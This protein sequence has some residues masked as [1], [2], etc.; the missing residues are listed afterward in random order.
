MESEVFS[1]DTTAT[2]KERA[3]FSLV[4]PVFEAAIEVYRKAGF[5]IIPIALPAFPAA[6]LYAIHNAEAGAMFEW[7]QLRNDANDGYDSR[8]F[9]SAFARQHIVGGLGLYA[10]ATFEVS[11]TT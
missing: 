4:R 11:S 8:W 1:I 10:E 7:D 5:E 9:A 3:R 6:A 2:E